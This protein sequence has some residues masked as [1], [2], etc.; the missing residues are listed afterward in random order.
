ARRA[1][2]RAADEGT[3]TA[4]AAVRES[5]A[6]GVGGGRV[7]REVAAE[8]RRRR[9]RIEADGWCGGHAGESPVGEAGDPGLLNPVRGRVTRRLRARRILLRPATTEPPEVERTFRVAVELAVQ[10]M[11]PHGGAERTARSLSNRVRPVD[12]VRLGGGRALHE[13]GP[14][15]SGED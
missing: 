5:R 1:E 2:G 6:V 4:D 13:P 9:R 8:V 3:G 15:L 10:V 7:D 11:E 14:Q 12:C